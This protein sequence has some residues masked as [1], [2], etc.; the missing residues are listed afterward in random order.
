[1]AGDDIGLQASRYDILIPGFKL[2]TKN[3]LFKRKGSVGLAAL[4]SEKYTTM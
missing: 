2:F 3:R 4:V 1:M